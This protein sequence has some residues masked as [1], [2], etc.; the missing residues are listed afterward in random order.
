MNCIYELSEAEIYIMKQF[1]QRGAMNSAE[2]A[3][4]VAERNWSR[5]ALYTFLSRLAAKGML[6]AEKS[7]KTNVYTPLITKQSYQTAMGQHFL[8]KLYDGCAKDFLVSMVSS[9]SLSDDDIRDLREW[10][11]EQGGFIDA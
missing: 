8:D 6:H 4:C 7:E 10:F 9:Q 2:I 11:A 3:K 5:S 1:W